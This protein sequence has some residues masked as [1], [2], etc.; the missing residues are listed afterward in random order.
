MPSDEIDKN[1]EEEEVE[2]PGLGAGAGAGLG[3]KPKPQ[4]EEEEEDLLPS[5]FGKRIKEAAERRERE[6]EMAKFSAS[7]SVKSKS[8]STGTDMAEF[9]RHT[10]GIGMRLLEKMGY[11]GG[12]LGKNQQG[13]AVPIQAKLR[14]KNMGMG[15]N[16]FREAGLPPA[17]GTEE[18][19][20]K[21]KEVK[22]KTKEKLWLKKNREK[23][24]DYVTAAELLLQKMEKGVEAVQT[25]LDMRGPQVRVL[26]NLENLNAEQVAIEENV[27]MPE[28]QH[29][30]RLIV[31]L[32]EADIQ[33]YDR[34]LRHERE[35]VVLLERE[36]ER[37]Q[38]EVV[39]QKQQ[40]E[41]ME[42]LMIGISQIKMMVAEGG[43]SLEALADAF[44]NLQTKY[45]ED[46]KLH[47]LSVIALSFALPLTMSLFHGWEPLVQ[48]LRGI[49][50][51]GLWQG[52]LQGNEPLDYSI[53]PETEMT[54]NWGTGYG[55]G[56]PPPYTL[57]V[58][59]AVLP[60]VRTATT[61]TWE[62]RDPE[63]MLRFLELWEKLLPASVLQSILEHLIMPKL[64]LAVDA[65]DPL[66]ETV[67][68]HAWLHPWLPLLGSRMDPLYMPI[69]FK[70]GNALQ[71]W[72][73][74]DS[75]AY[76]LLS[77]WQAVF[78]PGSWEQLL[79]RSIVPKLMSALQELV[80]NPAHQQLEPFN[81]VMAWAK[82]LPIHHMAGMLEAGFFPKWQQ[83]LYHWLCC[84][85]NFDEVTQWY[86]GWKSLLPAEL[87]ANERIRRQLNVALEMMNQA[88]EG[89]PVVQ[90]GARENVSYLRVT[91]QRQFETQQQ[92][93]HQAASTAYSQQHAGSAGGIFG[94][95]GAGAAVMSLKEVVEVF[96]QEHDV[97]FLP[98]LGRM[99]EGLQVYGFGMVSISIDSAK[100]VVLA[101]TGEKWVSVSLEQLVEMHR[102][103]SGGRWK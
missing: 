13:I 53:F 75:S 19:G 56:S 39:R 4:G 25:V 7:K 74:S 87:L 54:G 98:K 93:Q 46:F 58:M 82:V 100:Q 68:I 96:A 102:S 34:K 42:A 103:R 21:A 5:A 41:N 63:P 77:P 2:R 20:D 90:P 66:L 36:R 69:R 49:D 59:E 3:F 73:P 40:L 43:M 86:L 50:I 30:M 95:N 61:N 47:N 17:P 79:V 22:P 37:L 55:G 52:V 88:V 33:N 28:L 72:H 8:A 97:Q 83:V 60:P 35:A 62:P 24:K 85:P 12:G 10:R 65:W 78:D 18:Q 81:W 6:R 99:H 23:K 1:V 14:P 44:V 27:P 16:D 71:A 38:I 92:Q 91:E 70:L 15:F 32:V 9:E 11:K 89:T 45:R 94:D 76:A 26:T 64:M 31:D 57:L 101:Q 51:M 84:N 29:N 67:P 80:V 48:P